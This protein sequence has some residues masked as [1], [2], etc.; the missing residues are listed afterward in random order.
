MAAPGDGRVVA[1]PQVG[2]LHL[3]STRTTRSVIFRDASCRSVAHRRRFLLAEPA[4]YRE[5]L[6][7]H[8]RDRQVNACRIDPILV[9]QYEPGRV[10]G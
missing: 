3:S 6:P 10:L 7:S 8:R 1:I 5:H 9:M 4:R 2:G